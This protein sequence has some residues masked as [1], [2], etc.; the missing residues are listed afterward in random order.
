VFDKILVTGGSG[1]VGSCVKG[2]KPS[3]SEVDLMREDDISEY[4]IDHKLDYVI[5]CAA[6]VG[7]VKENK[8]KPGEFFRDNMQMTLNLFEAC[9]KTGVKKI[10]NVLS[11]CVFPDVA[12]YPLT[13]DQ[14]H[15]GE[16]HSTNFAYAYAKRM[17]EVMSRA[18]RQQYNLNAVSVIPCNVYGPRDNFNLE[19]SHVL[20][21]LIHKCYLA[22]INNTD[23]HVWGTG[24]PTR[25]FIYSEDLGSILNWTLENYDNTDPLIVSS[26]QEISISAL[27]DKITTAMEFSGNII[28]NN[29]LDG[30]LKKPSDNSEFN[31]RKMKL[32]SIDEGIEKTVNWF[33]SN[34]KECRK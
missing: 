24:K 1:L 19:S 3:F 23:L 10:L 34:Y 31:K 20:P 29:E 16:P 6:K 33:V 21:A 18:Y 9:R 5:N 2:K 13:P 25:E 22:K 27:V 8:N 28:Y 32:T 15:K 30:Q 14:L 17:I 26:D 7:G 12:S 11:T 4:I